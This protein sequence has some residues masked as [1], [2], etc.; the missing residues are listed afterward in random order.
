MT[1]DAFILVDFYNVAESTRLAVRNKS[2]HEESW[3]R[4]IAQL[5]DWL[6]TS[7]SYSRVAVRV[8]G[9]WFPSADESVVS[10][11][12][13]M[14]ARLM[15]QAQRRVG[16]R[17]RMNFDLAVGP[18]DAEQVVLPSTLRE[19]LGLRH[20]R[21]ETTCPRTDTDCPLVALDSWRRGRCSKHPT[22][23]VRT[24]EIAMQRGQKLVD[25]LICTDATF[26]AY[27]GKPCILASNDDDMVPPVISSAGLPNPVR[28]LRIGRRKPSPYDTLI[29]S[30]IVDL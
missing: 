22:C 10:D 16:R 29:G 13:S 9:G 23:S 5:S 24:D 28:W 20:F 1:P 25:T 27:S 14:L 15:R 8:Y 19:T 6:L 30:Q 7:T 18:V 17:L 12:Y 3:G 2:D 11:D 26:L 4:L 21:C